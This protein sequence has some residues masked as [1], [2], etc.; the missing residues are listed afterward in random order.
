[1]GNDEKVTKKDL[2][3]FFSFFNPSK[4]DIITNAELVRGLSNLE[5]G[6][7]WFSAIS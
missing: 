6:I 1:M 3:K 2:D 5:G 4:P 7:L